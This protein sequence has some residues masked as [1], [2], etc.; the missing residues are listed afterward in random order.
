VLDEGGAHHGER[1]AGKAG[2]D[3]LDRREVDAG[4][5]ESRVD[6]EVHDR[7]EDCGRATR[8]STRLSSERLVGKRDEGARRGCE[9]RF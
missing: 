1:T 9:R 6:E 2:E 8:V 3:L 5:T 4:A 7:D